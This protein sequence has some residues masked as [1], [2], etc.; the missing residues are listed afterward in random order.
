MHRFLR[1]V[2]FTNV[3]SRKDEDRLIGLVM[4]GAD[5]VQKTNAGLDQTYTEMSREFGRGMGITVCG[6]YDEKG[7]FHLDHYFPYFRTDLVSVDD[8]VTVNKRVDTFAFTG[9]C[10]DAKIGVSLIFYLQN[11]YDYISLKFR[12]NEPYKARTGLSGLSVDGVIILGVMEKEEYSE[13][14]NHYHNRR[15]ELLSQAMNGD[16]EAIDDLAVE[17]LDLNERVQRRIDHEDLYSIV[18]STFIP[19]GSESDNYFIIGTIVNWNIT[20]NSITYEEIYHLLINCNDVIFSICINKKD[21][22]GYPAI[23]TRFKGV[24]WLQGNVDYLQLK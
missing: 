2:G 7:F 5:S 13:K 21:L 16:E 22:K 19:Y 1:S 24:I 12:E 17:D 4:D 11:A 23:G 18:E 15:T 14:R 3:I 6:E 10:E 8:D 9:M 20:T